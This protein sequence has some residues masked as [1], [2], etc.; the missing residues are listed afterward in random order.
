[1]KKPVDT[2]FGAGVATNG[3]TRRDGALVPEDERLIE[4][5]GAGRRVLYLGL[6]Q[7]ALA[8]AFQARACDVIVVHAADAEELRGMSVACER[9]I[10]RPIGAAGLIAEFRREEFDAIVLQGIAATAET[11]AELLP[12]VEH[13]LGRHGVLL[14]R[15]DP[16]AGALE[17]LEAVLER[18]GF[19][20]ARVDG[21][22]RSVENLASDLL[23]G[24][25][26]SHEPLA[27]VAAFRCPQDEHG[28]INRRLDVLRQEVRDARRDLG[29]AME[30][31]AGLERHIEALER[32]VRTVEQERDVAQVDAAN[33]RYSN[34]RLADRDEQLRELLLDAHEQLLQRDE[35]LSASL[36]RQLELAAP[37]ET[38]D[39]SPSG[40]GY[41]R[42]RQV[43]ARVRE[44]VEDGVP[45]DA[46]VAVASKGDD[47]LL[48]LGGRTAWH[49]PQAENGVYLGHH[50]ADGRE[51]VDQL[52]YL[53]QRGAQFL[54]VPGS[55]WWWLEH[56]VELRDHLET[57]Y[58][59]V[60]REHGVCLIV[61]LRETLADP[62]ARDR[63]G[64]VERVRELV[65]EVVPEGSIVAVVTHGD[66]DLLELGGGRT[67]RHLPQAEGGVY[68]GY[69]PADS[70]TAIA[71][72]EALREEG[73]AFLVIPAAQLWWLDYYA[74][75]A[76]H[77]SNRY[78]LVAR[79]AE[80]GVVYDLARR[81]RLLS[82]RSRGR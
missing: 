37:P 82:W 23:A 41:L 51:A 19:V 77:L 39:A 76:Q 79:S 62:S 69:H 11:L 38:G 59:T 75:F 28:L 67:G 47:E 10:G 66:D 49:L 74:E 2:A 32:A 80:A 54:V 58:A 45:R 35:E 13:A 29:A 6:P 64:L 46:V 14:A 31:R 61:D 21:D 15:S 81:S 24:T 34:K 56:Y 70:V 25:D 26:H 44:L 63:E 78:R 65:R 12:A 40:F 4:L 27:L 50:P 60:A 22:R 71:Q 16:R 7:A 9:V 68:A 43:L 20:V 1:V 52:E 5:V 8:H 30:V 36:A 33:L 72:L 57:H 42:Y 17:P 18:A 73:A 48:E 3:K 55:V 53:R